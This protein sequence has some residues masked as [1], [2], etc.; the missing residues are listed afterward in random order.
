MVSLRLR[1]PDVEAGEIDTHSLLTEFGIG[2]F[3][4]GFPVPG[5]CSIV[6]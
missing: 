1:F 2:L 6:M 3:L 4:A 5:G